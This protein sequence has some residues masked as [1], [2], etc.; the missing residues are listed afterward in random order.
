MASLGLER[1]HVLV[2][3]GDD[4][5]GRE[6]VEEFRST[7]YGFPCLGWVERLVLTEQQPTDVW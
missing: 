6:I 7:V 2:V 4:E 5:A 3:G 1:L